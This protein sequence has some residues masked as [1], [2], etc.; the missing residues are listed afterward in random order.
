MYV[1]GAG[2]GQERTSDP[3]EQLLTAVWVLGLNLAPLEEQPV[4]LSTLALA[5]NII[6]Y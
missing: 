4:R 6:L 3:L 5:P 2:G 1:A